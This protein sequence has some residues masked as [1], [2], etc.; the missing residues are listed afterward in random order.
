MLYDTCA[1]LRDRALS[2]STHVRSQKG[3]RTEQPVPDRP[4]RAIYVVLHRFA[5]PHTP[6]KRAVQAPRPASGSQETRLQNLQRGGDDNDDDDDVFFF[7]TPPKI[8]PQLIAPLHS[9]NHRFAASCL[10]RFVSLRRRPYSSTSASHPPSDNRLLLI[11]GRR[12]A[13]SRKDPEQ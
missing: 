12:L 11:S 1:S 3:Q 10:L 2:V 13:L 9:K 8:A 7:F 4:Y 5:F 6:K